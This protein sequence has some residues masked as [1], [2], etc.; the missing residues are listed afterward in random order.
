M[1]IFPL[2]FG[3]LGVRIAMCCE[4]GYSHLGRGTSLVEER[5][6]KGIL[7]RAIVKVM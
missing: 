5:R 2:A 4:M 3:F 7:C 6:S 1:D